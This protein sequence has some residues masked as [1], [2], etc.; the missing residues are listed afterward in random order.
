MASRKARPQNGPGNNGL[1]G[2]AKIYSTKTFNGN[3]IDDVGGPEGFKRGFHH[4]DYTTEQQHQQTG[5][6]NKNDP[7]YGA[8]LTTEEKLKPKSTADIFSPGTGMQSSEWRTNTQLTTGIYRP[9]QDER[10]PHFSVLKGE[11]LDAYRNTWTSD[12]PIGRMVRFQTEALRSANAAMP[13]KFQVNRVR[14]MPGTPVPVEKLRE[15][16]IERHGILAFSAMRHSLGKGKVSGKKLQTVLKELGL[17]VSKADFC[18]VSF[19]CDIMRISCHIVDNAAFHIPASPYSLPFRF[20]HFIHRLTRD[21]KS[22][23]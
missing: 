3:F 23:V 21:R 4:E 8:N 18:H 5:R 10:L 1:R 9:L 14:F 13:L 15:K 11:K 22:V 7:Y 12:N 2:G 19:F 6:T 16:L 17:E 20:W